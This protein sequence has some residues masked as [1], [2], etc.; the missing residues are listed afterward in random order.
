[1][2]R[3]T[4]E[5]NYRTYNGWHGEKTRL[6]VPDVGK[7]EMALFVEPVV[8]AGVVALAFLLLVGFLVWRL[9]PTATTRPVRILFSVAAVLASLPPV[10]HALLPA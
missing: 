3:R 4:T 10:L 7:F 8:I 9:T 6:R 1:L 2:I 5:V